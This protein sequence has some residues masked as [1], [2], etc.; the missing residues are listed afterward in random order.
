MDT[1][2]LILKAQEL[3]CTY[4]NIP[5]HKFVELAAE[6]YPRNA[7]LFHVAIRF[8]DEIQTDM[9]EIA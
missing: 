6:H 7:Y 8:Y 4:Y 9:M 2:V 3:A 1:E 5:R